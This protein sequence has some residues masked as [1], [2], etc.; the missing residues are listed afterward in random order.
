[1]GQGFGIKAHVEHRCQIEV[2]ELNQHQ[3]KTRFEDHILNISRKEC[4]GVCVC[5]S[6]GAEVLRTPMLMLEFQ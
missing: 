6:I 4:R 3:F 5:V 2:L 1:M